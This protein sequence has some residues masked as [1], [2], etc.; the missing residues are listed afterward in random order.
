MLSILITLLGLEIEYITFGPLSMTPFSEPQYIGHVQRRY[1]AQ[2]LLVVQLLLC[3]DVLVSI[4]NLKITS[5]PCARIFSRLRGVK[6]LLR[7]R[8][9]GVHCCYIES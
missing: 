6:A 7:E 3:G 9:I 5:S 8:A 2:L 4:N 1:A